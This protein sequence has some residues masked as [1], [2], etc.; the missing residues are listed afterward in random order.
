M[1]LISCPD[2]SEDEEL[3]GETT[4]EGVVLT[5]EACGHRWQRDL[6]PRCGLCGSEDLEVVPTSV[7]EEAGR[8]EQRTPSGI[9]D[10]QLCWSCG[11]R[12][13]TSSRPIPAEPGWKRKRA[14]LGIDWRQGRES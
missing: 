4:D 9:R 5:C 7:L 13:A 11:A 8:G 6:T 12:D 10:V 3:R 1:P 2:C 14:A